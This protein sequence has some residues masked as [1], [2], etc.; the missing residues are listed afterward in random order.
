MSASTTR[1]IELLGLSVA[2]IGNDRIELVLAEILFVVLA[3]HETETRE[4]GVRRRRSAAGESAK[5]ISQALP[6]SPTRVIAY[7]TTVSSSLQ[8]GSTA[9]MLRKLLTSDSWRRTK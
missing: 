5:L 7:P 2:D 6:P 1:R 4:E 3:Q 8:P 9:K